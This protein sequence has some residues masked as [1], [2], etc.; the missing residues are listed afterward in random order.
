MADVTVHLRS[1][2]S[3]NPATLS[4]NNLA[5]TAIRFSDLASF[6]SYYRAIPHLMIQLDP[7]VDGASRQV[8]QARTC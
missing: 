5:N 6:D 7:W 3:N 2:A 4:K 8:L 1:H